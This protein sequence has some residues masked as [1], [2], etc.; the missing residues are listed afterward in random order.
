[1]TESAKRVL[2][3]DRVSAFDRSGL[4][5]GVWCERHGFKVSTLDYWRQQF[6]AAGAV[7]QRLIPIRV[8]APLA[9]SSVGKI[10]IDIGSGI[11]LNADTNVD[12]DWLASLL[13]GLR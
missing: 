10:K 5:R 13:R 8:N 9:A 6:G 1:M 2:R 4:Q 11:C 12:A 7:K 3:R